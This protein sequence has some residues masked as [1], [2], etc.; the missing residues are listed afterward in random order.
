[1][2]RHLEMRWSHRETDVALA[3]PAG[4][5]PVLGNA[6]RYSATVLCPKDS[7]LAIGR[8][9]ILFLT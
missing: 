6:A 3:T 2:K 4:M 5:Q 7:T 9:K 1:M 8:F